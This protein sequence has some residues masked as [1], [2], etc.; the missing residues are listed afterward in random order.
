MNDQDEILADHLAKMLY[1][2]RASSTTLH[3]MLHS[4]LAVGIGAGLALCQANGRPASRLIDLAGDF[5]DWPV[6]EIA[7][8]EDFEVGQ[9][10]DSVAVN[11]QLLQ[12]LDTD[13]AV[14]DVAATALILAAVLHRHIYPDEREHFMVIVRSAVMSSAGPMSRTVAGSEALN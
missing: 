1:V 10:S 7:I 4:G 11:K 13:L 9:L 5:Y 8:P 3:Q 12:Q 2:L 6:A 14:A